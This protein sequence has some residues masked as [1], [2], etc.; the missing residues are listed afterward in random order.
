VRPLDPRLLRY[1]RQ[2]RTHIAVLVALG[3][4]TAALVI[5]QAQ[6]LAGA[7]TSAFEHGATLTTLRGTV[8]AL[9]AVL[10]GRAVI[11]WATEAASYRACAGVKSELR[12]RL[13]S[14]AVDLG[15]RWLAGE[16]GRGGGRRTAE[17]VTLATQGIDALDGYFAAYLPQL[18]LA[19][20]VPLA[21]LARV[22]SADL[23]AGATIAL[24][25][26]L[27]P[28][29]GALVGMA[30][31]AH[32]RRRYQALARLSYHFLDVVA[33]LATLKVFG[34]GRAQA[35]SIASV[36][37]D[38]RRA[39]LGTLRLAFLSSLVLELTATLS[40][41]LVAVGVGLRLVSGHL[42]LRTGLLAL[43]LAPEAYLP[44]RQLG[45][46]FHAS[47]DG[48]AAAG[49]ILAVLDEPDPPAAFHRARCLTGVARGR[50]AKSI[51]RSTSPL[52][53]GQMPQ[54]RP[55]SCVECPPLGDFATAPRTA[56]ARH[57]H[58]TAPRSAGLGGRP[59]NTPR[60]GRGLGG[61]PPN[62]P[63]KSAPA[64]V[65]APAP[66][67]L[68]IRVQDLRVEHPGR[69]EPAPDGVSLSVARGEIVA[70]TGP[71]GC[72]KSTLIAVLLGFTRPAAGQVIIEGPGGGTDLAVLA[73]GGDA[74]RPP[75][76]PAVLAWRDDPPILPAEGVAWGD[77]SPIPPA[78]G[79]A[80]GDDASRPP[81]PPAAIAPGEWRSRVSWVPQDP[82]LFAGTV[83][84][85]IRLGKPDAPDSEVR[86]AA[87]AAALD[88]V[89]TDRLVGER[90]SGLSA[91]QRRRV[92]VA[93]ALLPG[94]PV[95]LL[96]EP[97]AGLDA[98]AEARVLATLRGEA[99]AG[100][101]VLVVTHRPAVL[102]AADRVIDLAN[103]QE[104]EPTGPVPADA[105]P[106]GPVPADAVPTGPVPTDTVPTDTVPTDA[107][108]T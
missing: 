34:R 74:S 25:L 53:V 80:W 21:V 39:T 97:T 88:D 66:E 47:A 22:V 20:V 70:L 19:F 46:Q 77:D 40:V 13:L 64:L 107:V 48:L 30:T 73:W 42:D 61:R 35:R 49:E 33:G 108:P 50:V 63:R 72:G 102:A 23:L 86:A 67:L 3:L 57:P 60:G 51:R 18:V 8:A 93:R 36:T 68:A 91:G 82:V 78:E 59:P 94:R 89:A 75:I 58:E 65:P 41:A 101:A 79:V 43:I 54:S 44:L 45:A 99:V 38:Y 15:P 12:R 2:A 85:N 62:T 71:S 103:T 83:A 6:L 9:A 76:P 100:R 56:L 81:I 10:A 5:T 17:L 52:H 98:A 31:Q 84:S 29:F 104:P 32:A 27:I 96:D 7:I 37:D 24:T 11:G 69:P 4:A 16:G 90:G 95:L 92:A 55:T 106:T 26:P 14:R 28:L 1:A 105:V 87:R